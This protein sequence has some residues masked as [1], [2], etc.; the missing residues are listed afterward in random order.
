[1]T[2]QDDDFIVP[3][4]TVTAPAQPEAREPA[5]EAAG[6]DEQEFISLPPGMANFDSGTYRMP[7]PRRSEPV[8]SDSAPL[9]VPTPVPG[10]PPQLP[11]VDEATRVA[12]AR[13]AAGATAWVLH[14]PG[15]DPVRLA[16]GTML[17]GRGPAALTGWPQ[18]ML[19]PVVDPRK[20]VSKTHA[21]LEVAQ[22]GALRVHDLDSTNG[23]W[24][25]YPNGDEVDV[26]PG[27]PVVVED[28]AT[29]HLGEFEILVR[30][31]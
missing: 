1:M 17:L 8:V 26:E 7:T 31:D 16:S 22:G 11:G 23:V 20:S 5:P 9:F 3:P 14:L 19:L 13:R 6:A 4:A 21:A 12:P 18:A 24:L 2:Q 30:R 25:S 29:M 15:T 28:G 27:T 10:L